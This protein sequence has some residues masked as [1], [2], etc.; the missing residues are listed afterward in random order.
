MTMPAMRAQQAP[1]GTSDQTARRQTQG[2]APDPKQEKKGLRQRL[3]DLPQAAGIAIL[4]VLLALSLPVGNFRALQNATPGAFI[5]QGDV[6]SIVEDRVAAAN[7]ACTVASRASV[8]DTLLTDVRQAARELG[9]AKTAREISRADQRLTSAVSG[10]TVAASDALDAENQ[11]MLA[12][13]ADDF[14][15][16]GSFLRQEARAFNEKAEKAE[17]LYERLPM[18]FMLPQPDVYEGV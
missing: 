15:E 1:K 6:R 7:N 14:A 16:Q 18:K 17:K 8:S 2:N 3:C 10:M 9:E 12:S 13:A 11:R 4:C 5:R